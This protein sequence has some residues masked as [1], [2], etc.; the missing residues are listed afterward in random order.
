MT[1][2]LGLPGWKKVAIAGEDALIENLK[3]QL[4][5][6]NKQYFSNGEFRQI[7]NKIA[8]GNIFD[9]AKTLGCM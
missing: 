5:K 8:R 4:E 1:A 7:M 6:H 9:K 3:T 2:Q